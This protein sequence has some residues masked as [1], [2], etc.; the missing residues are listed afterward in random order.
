MHGPPPDAIGQVHAPRS[1]SRLR[2]Q[3]VGWRPK[4]AARTLPQAGAPR[5]TSARGLLS[6]RGRSPAVFSIAVEIGQQLLQCQSWDRLAGRR[7]AT[8]IRSWGKPAFANP[9]FYKSLVLVPPRRHDLGDDTAAVGDHDGLTG[10]GQPDIFAQ[11]V[12]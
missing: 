11:L 12:L 10:R 4:P 9:A 5:S 1:G 6:C 8:L 2:I 7:T 3:A